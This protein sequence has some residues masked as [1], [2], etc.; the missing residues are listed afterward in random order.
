[1]KIYKF[2]L[3]QIS[4]EKYKLKS[5]FYKVENYKNL[6]IINFKFSAETRKKHN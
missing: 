2:S 1:M 5:I 3:S 4:W 6:G